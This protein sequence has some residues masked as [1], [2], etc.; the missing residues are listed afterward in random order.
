[1]KEMVNPSDVGFSVALK[2]LQH[3]SEMTIK[4]TN[5]KTFRNIYRFA[6]VEAA[7]CVKKDM[8]LLSY[9]S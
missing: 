7:R 5:N 4:S 3:Y 1:M 2:P 8:Q 6:G 9:M